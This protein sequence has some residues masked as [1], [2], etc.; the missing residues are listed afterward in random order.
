MDPLALRVAFRYIPKETK[1][2]KVDRLMK[3]LRDATGISRGLA[4]DI[5]DAII[6]RRDLTGL[7]LQKKWPV[8]DG[9]LTGPSGQFDL[10]S[11]T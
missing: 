4:E 11:L 8:E 3:I 5:A 6:R 9:L 7:A 2:H 10:T 1:Q